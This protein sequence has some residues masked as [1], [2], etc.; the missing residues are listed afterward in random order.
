[1]NQTHMK[2]VILACH[3]LGEFYQAVERNKTKARDVFA[4]NCEEQHFPQSCFSLGIIHLTNK[5]KFIS[6]VNM[7]YL[8]YIWTGI[9][10][11]EHVVT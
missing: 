1:M 6:C 10:L 4:K 8:M 7:L 3:Q 11:K 9:G 2:L 5:G